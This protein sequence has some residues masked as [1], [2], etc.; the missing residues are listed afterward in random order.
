M[1]SRK[2]TMP[3]DKDNPEESVS[4]EDLIARALE[5]TTT[6]SSPTSSSPDSAPPPDSYQGSGANPTPP[7]GIDSDPSIPTRPEVWQPPFPISPTKNDPYLSPP[8]Q[9]LPVEPATRQAPGEAASA[10]TPRPADRIGSP[11]PD[12]SNAVR[13]R[14]LIIGALALVLVVTGM[15]LGLL[16]SSETDDDGVTT[17]RATATTFLASTASSAPT[18]SIAAVEEVAVGDC[19]NDPDVEQVASIETIPCE[20]SHDYEVM[21]IFG[22]P[23]GDD[24]PYPGADDL[25]QAAVDGCIEDFQQYTGLV[26]ENETELFIDAFYP[27]PDSWDAGDREAWC[28]LVRI[29]PDSFEIVPQT[30]SLR[31]N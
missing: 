17:A 24:A 4:S 7:P 2:H 1:L 25:W 30:R 16:A 28:L 29:D 19:F 11:D 13:A 22:Y 20:E 10:P 27:L 18:T 6:G 31:S 9:P 21:Q 26:W 12:T 8:P 15:V 3:H 14:G 23:Q 5:A